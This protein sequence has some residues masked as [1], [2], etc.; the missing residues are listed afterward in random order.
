MR[1]GRRGRE[2]V[3]A[4]D[5]FYLETKKKLDARTRKA[6]ASEPL[7][8]TAPA[9]AHN[10]KNRSPTGP[11]CRLVITTSRFYVLLHSSSLTFGLHLDSV[12][13]TQRICAFAPR[14]RPPFAAQR[15]HLG[16]RTLS[17]HAQSIGTKR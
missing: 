5:A 1:S 11:T 9:T 2:C 16:K 14:S 7:P 8:L 10:R 4:S 12:H 6:R 15:K 3:R 13:S 17:P